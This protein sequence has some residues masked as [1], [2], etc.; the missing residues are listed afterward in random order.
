VRPLL[1]DLYRV[2][3][4]VYFG[5]SVLSF[6]ARILKK[7]YIYIYIY[8]YIHLLSRS[9]ARVALPRRSPNGSTKEQQLPSL[10][11]RFDKIDSDVNVK[12]PF[13]SQYTL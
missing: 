11:H 6:P 8:M 4:D 3:S 13:G 9:Y 12:I 1:L 2:L 5:V 10:A 7:K